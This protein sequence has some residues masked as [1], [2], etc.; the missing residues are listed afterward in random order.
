MRRYE[1]G[2]SLNYAKSWGIP[3]AVREFF[4]NALDEEKQNPE[5]KMSIFYDEAEQ[6]LTIS[7]RKSRL[8]PKTLLLGSSTKEGNPE[9]IG[10]HGEGY[11]VATAVLMRNGVTVKIYNNEVNEVWTSR[12]VK[13][14]RY[15]SDIVCFDVTKEVFNKDD[16]L[17]IDLIGITPEMYAGVVKSN[18]HLRDDV[19]EVKSGKVGSI[20][21]DEKFRGKIYVEGLYVCT[22][23]E[24]EWGYN[25]SAS[26]AKL[27]RDRGLIDSFDL[28]FTIAKLVA[29]LEDAEFIADNINKP[30]LRFIATYIGIGTNIREEASNRAYA[31][32]Q[33]E[34]GDDAVPVSSTKEFNRY[35]EMGCKA[36]MVSTQVKEV[37]DLKERDYLKGK[38]ISDIDRE[39]E[40]WCK[41]AHMHLPSYLFEAIQDLW[42]R[43]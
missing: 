5:N 4:Q 43:K 12:V 1:L 17:V 21:L 13:S 24:L 10:E 2:I 37:I 33:E 42:Q 38:E 23:S 7:N 14:K 27:D 26:V 34:Y 30:D 22:K 20:L 39:F 3:E 35:T 8:T 18:L 28:K 41:L 40:D 6:I 16:D 15:D 11:K 9:L 19:G 25:L 31:K 36:V 29:G 32:F